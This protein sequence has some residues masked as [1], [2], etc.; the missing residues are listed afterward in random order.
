LADTLQASIQFAFR[1]TF[2]M[3]FGL[4]VMPLNLVRRG[5]LPAMFWSLLGLQAVVAAAVLLNPG[6]TGNASAVVTLAALI[7]VL[8]GAGLWAARGA[9]PGLIAGVPYLLA[10]LALV[11][12]IPAMAWRGP[13]TGVGVILVMADVVSSGVLLGVLMT[14]LFLGQWYLSTPNMKLIPWRQFVQLIGTAAAARTALVLFGLVVQV[15][16]AEAIASLL[17]VYL[18]FRWLCCV[19][20]VVMLVLLTREMRVAGDSV[21]GIGRWHAGLLLVF[22]GELVSQVAPVDMLYPL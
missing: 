9:R 8:C 6:P 7:A 22:L 11:A 4:G 10:F 3:A 5:F 17:L 20:G 21:G 15:R 18:V 14:L 1:F 2:G 19:L 12:A 13:R 16:S